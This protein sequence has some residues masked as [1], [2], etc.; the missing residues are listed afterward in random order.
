M[1]EETK[2]WINKGK[3]D[4]R[5]AK[6]NFK[7]G[8]YDLVSFLCQQ[9]VEKILKAMLIEKTKT[10]PKI[11]DLVR[12]GRMVNLEDKMINK[13]KELTLAY[14]YTRY[15]DLPEESDLM[16]KSTGFLKIAEE[17]L[18]WVEENQ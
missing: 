16:N 8:N 5:K 17:V 4:L 11:H 12:L 2:N 10:F 9:C 14:A 3:D 18:Q 7:M 13:F 6:D 1:R 15:P